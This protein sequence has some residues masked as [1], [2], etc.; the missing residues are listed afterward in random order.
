MMPVEEKEKPEANAKMGKELAR[1]PP[2]EQPEIPTIKTKTRSR[3][4]L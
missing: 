4:I 1:E 3:Q 2:S